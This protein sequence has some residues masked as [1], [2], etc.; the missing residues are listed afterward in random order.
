MLG[1]IFVLLA[2]GVWYFKSKYLQEFT[3]A[4]KTF[5]ATAYYYKDMQIHYHNLFPVYGALDSL[6]KELKLTKAPQKLCLF[7]DSPVHVEDPKLCR[8]CIGFIASESLSK[9]SERRVKEM[10]YT[11]VDLPSWTGVSTQMANSGKI[12]VVFGS[13]RAYPSLFHYMAKKKDKYGPINGTPVVEIHGEK[14]ITYAL[15]LGEERKAFALTKYPA[16]AKKQTKSKTD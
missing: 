12:A 9:E 6:F 10:E 14:F 13:M 8:A 11:K 5:E 1:I 2:I 15:P 7:F 16:P 4:K 3:F